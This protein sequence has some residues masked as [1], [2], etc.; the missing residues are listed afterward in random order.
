MVFNAPFNNIS[1]ISWLLVLLVEKT[2]VPGENH[3]PFLVTDKL[4]PN[5]E[6]VGH[7]VYLIHKEQTV[8]ELIGETK[9]YFDNPLGLL[10]YLYLFSCILNFI[11]LVITSI[12][13]DLG[14]WCLTPLYVISLRTVLIGGGNRIK[15]PTCR[16]SLTN[17]IT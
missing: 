4:Y 2:G 16:K 5:I 17:F 12:C 7:V 1:V 3:Q 15:P 8:K 13:V 11:I 14:L 10:L 9:L 6:H